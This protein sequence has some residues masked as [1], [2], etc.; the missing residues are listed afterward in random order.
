VKTR[1]DAATGANTE[2]AGGEV[3]AIDFFQKMAVRR[4]SFKPCFPA[5]GLPHQVQRDFLSLGL[6]KDLSTPSGLFFN[7]W[8]GL[9]PWRCI[10]NAL[11]GLFVGTKWV[12]HEGLSI[13]STQKRCNGKN[14][15]RIAYVN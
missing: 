5:R 11:A 15:R 2:L 12:N 8:G 7:K 14:F 6:G 10:S 9:C 3:D 4:G 13:E 1:S